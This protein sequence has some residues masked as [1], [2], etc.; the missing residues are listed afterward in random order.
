MIYINMSSSSS[1]SSSP[2]S[3]SAAASSG[4]SIYRIQ[5]TAIDSGAYKRTLR[6][7][8]SP[9]TMGPWVMRRGGRLFLQEVLA[10]SHCPAMQVCV[11]RILWLENLDK[12]WTD[13]EEEGA[14]STE[15]KEQKCS[16]PVLLRSLTGRTFTLT[17]SPQD[18]V[19][20]APPQSWEPHA[21]S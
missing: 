14:E 18:T 1:S 9:D 2:S 11:K 16:V 19:A 20:D 17:L 3:S 21:N 10:G 7:L 8:T 5:S 4:L 6:V 13:E 15:K 12:K